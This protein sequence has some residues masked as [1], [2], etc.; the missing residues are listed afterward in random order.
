[1]EVDPSEFDFEE[2]PV[3]THLVV[4]EPKTVVKVSGLDQIAEKVGQSL[5]RSVEGS[6]SYYDSQDEPDQQSWASIEDK[7]GAEEF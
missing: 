3:G 4:L 7:D 2:E 1:M 6:N 5:T